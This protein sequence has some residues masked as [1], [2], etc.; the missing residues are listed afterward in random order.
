MHWY[1]YMHLYM[2]I[3]LVSQAGIDS[4]TLEQNFDLVC[5]RCMPVRSCTHLVCMLHSVYAAYG[6]CAV[7]ML[8]ASEK[9]HTFGV[10]MLHASEMHHTFGV[11][12]V[13]C[14][15]AA[16]SVVISALRW[17]T[18]MWACELQCLLLRN[19]LLLPTA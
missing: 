16:A 13:W 2:C 10:C 9:H 18:Y 7:C 15:C 14:V 6:V 1:M 3:F 11:Y 4:G 19:A 8:H 5:V 17:N 12:A